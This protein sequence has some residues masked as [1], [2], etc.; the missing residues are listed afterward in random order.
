ME[1][2][3]YQQMLASL[4]GL[5]E[6]QIDALLQAL[7]ERQ[8]ADG[9]Q[10]LIMARLAQEGCCRRCQ[11]TSKYKHGT[12]FGA[13]RFRCKDCGK[14]FTATTGTPFHRLR[15]KS[16]LLERT[17]GCGT[18]RGVAPGAGRRR[19]AQ[20]R[21]Q[22]RLLDGGRGVCRWSRDTLSR[23]TT[24]RAARALACAERQPLRLQP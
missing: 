7:R 21:R 11:S 5:T 9:V 18:Y 19:G 10:R 4:E 6:A 13:Q 1:Q 15:D 23:S 12:E 16:K 8:D 20:N 22:R 17:C 14:T 3:Q 2:A 24:A